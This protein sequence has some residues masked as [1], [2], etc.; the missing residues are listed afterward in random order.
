MRA[1][2]GADDGAKPILIVM[3]KAPRAGLGKQ[4]LATAIGASEALRIN[5]ALQAMT[6]RQAV[7]TRWRTLLYV[8]PDDALRLRISAW[9]GRVPRRPQ[10]AGDLG[11]RLAR[12]LAPYRKVA[13][14]GADCPLLTRAHIAAAFAALRRAPFAIGPSKDGGFYLLAARDGR[15]A[16]RAMAPVR[17]STSHAAADV[18]GNLAAPTLRL[19]ELFDIDTRAELALWRALRSADQ[20][21]AGVARGVERGPA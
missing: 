20:R 17:W 15:A 19:P 4:R 9:P 6:L 7:D 21:G 8:A 12:A 1:C 10:G 3:A 5:R 14:I 16:A 11:A 2:A 13:V 18:L